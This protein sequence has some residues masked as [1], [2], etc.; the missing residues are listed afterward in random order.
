LVGEKGDERVLHSKWTENHVEGV[1]VNATEIG[2]LDMEEDSRALVRGTGV[3]GGI[4]KLLITN[5]VVGWEQGLPKAGNVLVQI[6]VVALQEPFKNRTRAVDH[7][8]RALDPGTRALDP[9]TRVLGPGSD[10]D[11]IK[12]DGV[13]KPQHTTFSMYLITIKLFLFVALLYCFFFFKLINL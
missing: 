2:R 8:T 11:R 6:V 3:L 9:G 10:Q 5:R 4:G 1:K 7:G 13:V 12:L